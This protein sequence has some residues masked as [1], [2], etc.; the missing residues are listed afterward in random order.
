[1][2][3]LDQASQQTGVWI[4]RRALGEALLYRRIFPGALV[5]ASGG[6]GGMASQATSGLSGVRSGGTCNEQP[7][8]HAERPFGLPCPAR[9]LSSETFVPRRLYLRWPAQ[10]ASRAKPSAGV[11]Y[12]YGCERCVVRFDGRASARKNDLPF[13]PSLLIKLSG[14]CPA[15][16]VPADLNKL[17][18]GSQLQTVNSRPGRENCPIKER[19]VIK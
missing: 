6:H 9:K 12:C 11:R 17:F 19:P 8:S 1:M 15:E 10:L 3:P 14:E 7:Y 2:L 5:S 4:W 18:Y 16:D 13:I